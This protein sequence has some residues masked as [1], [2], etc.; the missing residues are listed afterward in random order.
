VRVVLAFGADCMLLELKISGRILLDPTLLKTAASR[1]AQAD[2]GA[3]LP[4]RQLVVNLI[5]K[6]VKTRLA[7]ASTELN[8]DSRFTHA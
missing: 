2:R 1:A 5:V 4:V 8:I 3:E 6:D 7:V